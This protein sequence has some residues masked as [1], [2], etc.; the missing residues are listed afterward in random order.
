[1]FPHLFSL[2]V[3]HHRRSPCAEGSSTASSPSLC[4]VQQLDFYMAQMEETWLH[5]GQ[6]CQ[7]HRALQPLGPEKRLSCY[8]L[9]KVRGMLRTHLPYIT[10]IRNKHKE[11]GICREVTM[12][13]KILGV[14]N[15]GN[16]FFGHRHI[17]ICWNVD[18]GLPQWGFIHSFGIGTEVVLCTIW[19]SWS[20]ECLLFW[21]LGWR[22][23]H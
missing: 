13:S 10:H 4:R 23:S 22:H 1:M 20:R 5:H 8:I 12:L 6:D 18:L 17:Q 15:A 9:H 19:Y 3:L 2:Y 21:Q 16:V 11:G 14:W 7:L